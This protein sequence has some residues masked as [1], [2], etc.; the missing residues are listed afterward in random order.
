M[1]GTD[2]PWVLMADS[3]PDR[4]VEAVRGHGLALLPSFVAGETLEV[5]AREFAQAYEPAREAHFT[6]DRIGGHN[7]R[8]ASD[9]LAEAGLPSTATFFHTDWMRS[10]SEAYLGSAGIQ[11][12]HEVFICHHTPTEAR[13]GQLPYL[14][15]FDKLHTFKFFVYL[16]DTTVASGPIEVV[17]GSHAANREARVAGADNVVSCEE[18]DVVP[19]TGPAGTRARAGA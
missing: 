1:N 17:P 16:E 6:H 4:V 9:G 2:K 7:L 10:I 3:P 18:A 8:T 5:L 14:M 15:H 13:V 19:V 12:N 11:L